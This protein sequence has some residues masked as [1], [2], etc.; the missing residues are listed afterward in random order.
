VYDVVGMWGI[1]SVYHY[2]IEQSELDGVG[3][4]FC[5]A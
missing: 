2:K 4:L 1:I 3:L 5:A